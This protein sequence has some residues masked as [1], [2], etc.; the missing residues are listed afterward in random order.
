MRIFALCGG[1][2]PWKSMPMSESL[3]CGLAE[4]REFLH[5]IRDRRWCLD[6]P[7]GPLLGWSGLEC[8][9]SLR[10]V[11][12]DLLRRPCVGVNSHAVPRRSAKELVDRDSQCLALD[13]PQGH[14]YSRERRGQ[15][16]ATSVEGVPINR[17]PVEL[18]SPRVFPDQVGFHLADGF[19]GRLTS[20]LDNWLAQANDPRVG[21]DL[22]ERPARLHADH[23][24]LGDTQIFA[25]RD[26]GCRTRP[27]LSPEIVRL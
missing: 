22:E 27:F 10:V 12:F 4:F 1:I 23:L 2:A 25:R 3:S 24:E 5:R 15:H 14:I 11:L 20:R 17:L 19:R 8:P 16:R 7:I 18:H 13:V 6:D 26:R 21:M 9:K